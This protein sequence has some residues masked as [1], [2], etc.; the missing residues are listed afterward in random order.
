MFFGKLF[1]KFSIFFFDD[2]ERNSLIFYAILQGPNKQQLCVQDKILQT[3]Q[4]TI[5]ELPI[6]NRVCLRLIL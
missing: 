3:E 6:E 4:Q 2:S 1:Q 5:K